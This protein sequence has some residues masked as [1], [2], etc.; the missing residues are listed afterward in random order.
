MS[1][2]FIHG[3]G[4]NPSVWHLQ[5][6]HFKDSVAVELPGHPNGSGLRSIEDYALVVERQ[7]N[8][9]GI[10]NP[11]I[12]GHSMGGAIA[13][14]LALR[15]RELRALVLVGTGARLRVRAEFLAKV[16]E[17]YEEA[18]KL[19]ASWSV[20]SSADPILVD[21][22]ARDLLKVKPEVALGDFMA[23]DM[24]DRMERVGD[25]ACRALVLCGEDDRMTPKKYSQYLH[26]KI[27]NSELVIIPGAGHAVMLEKSGEFNRVLEAFL[28]SL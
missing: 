7:I 20:S 15:R 17:D 21:R 28:V 18:V 25:I 22:T 3:A 12:V 10:T 2:L 4:A 13:I 26:E 8:E 1:I 27:K 11:I 16:K 5:T 23:C 24:F 9:K 6:V 19:L 14:E